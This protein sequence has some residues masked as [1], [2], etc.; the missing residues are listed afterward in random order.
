MKYL[1]AIQ[2]NAQRAAF[3]V[4]SP[5][6]CPV[7][8]AR[9]GSGNMRQCSLLCRA[10]ASREGATGCAQRRRCAGRPAPGAA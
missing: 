9:H 5:S 2:K 1:S 8:A 10:G 4:S 6:A 3:K 7:H